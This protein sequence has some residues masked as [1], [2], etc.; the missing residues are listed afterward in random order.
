MS[1]AI[2]S[3]T[4]MTQS[5]TMCL[6]H[7]PIFLKNPPNELLSL[8]RK[9]PPQT[10]FF[11]P[12]TS[13]IRVQANPVHFRRPLFDLNINGMISS[14]FI[15]HV[16]TF[17][18]HLNIFLNCMNQIMWRDISWQYH[19]MWHE[20][21]QISYQYTLSLLWLYLIFI[22]NQSSNS[23]LKKTC[24]LALLTSYSQTCLAILQSLKTWIIVSTCSTYSSHKLSLNLTSLNTC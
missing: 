5:S 11:L 23:T 15:L 9:T 22:S 10:A 1:L 20:V 16:N 3:P 19:M 21:A 14:D 4:K 7:L 18:V 6:L 13:P 12:C 8:S 17:V 24:L 2:F